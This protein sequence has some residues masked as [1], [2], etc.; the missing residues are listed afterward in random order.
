[1]TFPGA[2]TI[3]A[4]AIGDDALRA[5]IFFLFVLSSALVLIETPLGRVLCEEELVGVGAEVVAVVVVVLDAEVQGVVEET[6]PSELSR[7]SG[8]SYS[9]TQFLTTADL[10]LF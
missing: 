1:M 8:L 9:R 7:L 6:S 2:D 10:M 3:K 4:G 5:A